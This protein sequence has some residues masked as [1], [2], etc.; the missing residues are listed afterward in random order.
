MVFIPVMMQNLLL[1]NAS[2]PAFF[3]N[4]LINLKAADNSPCRAIITDFPE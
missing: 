4:V 1:G 2:I 3:Y